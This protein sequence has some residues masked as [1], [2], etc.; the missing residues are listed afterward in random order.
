LVIDNG[1]GEDRVGHLVDVVICIVDYDVKSLIYLPSAS[2]L[3]QI[4]DLLVS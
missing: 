1:P 3:K 2:E 4:V